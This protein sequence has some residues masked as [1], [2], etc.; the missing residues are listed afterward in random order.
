MK[1]FDVNTKVTYDTW[2]RV[3]AED[4]ESAKRKVDDMVWDMTSIQYQIMK[5]AKSSGEVKL[6]S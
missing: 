5:E 4:E 1:T 3:Q 2:V 6:I